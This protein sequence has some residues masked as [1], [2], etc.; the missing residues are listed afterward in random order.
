MATL[1][2]VYNKLSEICNIQTNS[3]SALESI[4]DTFETSFTRNGGDDG[5]GTPWSKIGKAKEGKGGGKGAVAALVANEISASIKDTLDLITKGFSGFYEIQK[6]NIKAEKQIM[7]KRLEL[8]SDT[9]KK[10]SDNMVNIL[11]GDLAEAMYTSFKNN[12]D[13]GLSEMNKRIEMRQI[14]YDRAISNQITNINALNGV[15]GGALGVAGKNFASSGAPWAVIVGTVL[16]TA[17]SIMQATS[18]IEIERLKAEQEI[19]TQA[20]DY[21]KEFNQKMFALAES[22]VNLGQNIDKMLLTIDQSAYEMARGLGVGAQASVDYKNAMVD[23]NKEMAQ[24]GKNWEAIAKIQQ[25]YIE[26]SDRNF[27][28][29]G[30]NA[31]QTSAIGMLFGIGDAESGAIMGAMNVFNKS[32]ESGSNMMFNMYKTATR[33]GVSNQKFAKDLQNTLKLSQRYQFKDGVKGVMEMALWAQKVRFNI[34]E[35]EGALSKMHTGNIEDVIQTSARLNVLGGNAAL[36]SNP[37]AMLFNAYANPKKYMENINNMIKGFGTIDRRSGETTFGIAE[38]MRI[39]QIAN[40]TG[41]SAE[42]LF[43]QARQANKAE[44]IKRRF[45]GRFGKSTDYIANNALWDE[46]KGTWVVNVLGEGGKAV[47]KT[48]EELRTSDIEKIFPEDK[49]DQLL[50]YVGNMLSI[51]EDQHKYE[52]MMRA[53]LMGA[54]STEQEGFH[55]RMNRAAYEEA[56]ADFDWHRQNVLD[57]YKGA[58]ESTKIQLELNRKMR[59]EFD[60]TGK[61]LLST[62]TAMSNDA[63]RDNITAF[64]DMIAAFSSEDAFM[65]YLKKYAPELYDAVQKSGPIDLNEF[66]NEFGNREVLA[67]RQASQYNEQARYTKSEIEQMAALRGISVGKMKEELRIGRYYYDR[68][69]GILYTRRGSNV[70][71]VDKNAYEFWRKASTNTIGGGRLKKSEWNQSWL[72]KHP[73]ERY[74]LPNQQPTS[75]VFNNKNFGYNPGSDA[76]NP[77]VHDAIITPRGTVYT[78]PDDTIM[79]FKPGGPIMNG[80]ANG[81][82]S[83]L[84]INGTLKLE[85]NGQSVDLIDLVKSNPMVWREITEKVITEASQNLYGRPKYAPQRYTIG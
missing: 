24:V 30:K 59:E 57:F 5:S 7:S 52:N 77:H 36:L 70:G 62:V 33:M 55:R 29:T 71:V 23:M 12:L 15:I 25:A 67:K 46:E 26:S 63:F 82:F 47:E 64:S 41:V 42:S 75:P 50:T 6:T 58:E 66:E 32:I 20:N 45:G 69:R 79:A 35:M 14:E 39:E 4:A 38:Q 48:L 3:Y 27:M 76:V 13:F 10:A 28:M 9:L 51:M 44:A 84:E 81:G 80:M 37:M 68:N 19:I 2:E 49:Q 65:V 40:A 85:S 78:H 16:N 31:A 34:N 73:S 21:R 22:Q 53:E 60:K 74:D 18:Q 17:Q 11:T 54:T 1:N 72:E 83:K 61:T 56:E 8:Y 43:N